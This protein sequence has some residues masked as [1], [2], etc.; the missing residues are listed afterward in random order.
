VAENP[1]RHIETL[2]ELEA[3][4]RH[5]QIR[6]SHHEIE[7]A[8]DGMSITCSICGKLWKFAEQR[9]FREP[10]KVFAAEKDE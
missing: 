4:K 6:C 7:L 9:G 3:H 5:Y 1:V 8:E 10:R 2:R